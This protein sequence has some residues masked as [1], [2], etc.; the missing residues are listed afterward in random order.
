MK[1]ITKFHRTQIIKQF[2][3]ISFFIT[4]II[5]IQAGQS[6]FGQSAYG[7]SDL[8]RFIR[9]KGVKNLGSMA[10]AFNNY[11][12]G[13]YSIDGDY[14]TIEVSYDNGSSEVIKMHYEPDGDYFENVRCISGDECLY[15]FVAAKTIVDIIV[16]DGKKTCVEHFFHTTLRAMSGQQM[17]AAALTSMW[18][19]W[20]GKQCN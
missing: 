8:E 19:D 16:P 3:A 2:K 6:A 14:I 20:E 13:N 10:H 7:A 12:G 1:N 11:S 15:S 18:W 17:A 5:L 4:I 9:A